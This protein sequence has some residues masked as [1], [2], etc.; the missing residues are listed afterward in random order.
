MALLDQDPSMVAIH[1]GF[2]G[3]IRQ[4]Q[5]GE[6]HRIILNRSAVVVSQNNLKPERR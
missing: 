1:L 4:H 3:I 6:W 5:P 2:D